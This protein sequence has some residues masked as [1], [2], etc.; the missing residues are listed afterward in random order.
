RFGVSV[1]AL[2]DLNGL[3]RRPLLRPG[4]IVSLP[5]RQVSDGPATDRARPGDTLASIAARHRRSPADIQRA[6]AMGT[7]Q[8]LVEG[9]L[10]NL[11]GSGAMSTRPRID[12]RDLPSL[13]ASADG[14]PPATVEAA[15][16]NRRSVLS[17]PVPSRA[18]GRALVARID[19]ERERDQHLGLAGA[20]AESGFNH[21]VVS[22]G[23]AIGIMQATPHAGHCAGHAI[24]RALDVLDPVDNGTAG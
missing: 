7:S 5:E 13:S 4:Q 12:A 20:Q 18:A 15:R 8:I 2:V 24:G 10:L 1:P 9:E 23:T 16:I 19:G 3:S 21:A 11:T 6:N 14:Y 22:P 17:R